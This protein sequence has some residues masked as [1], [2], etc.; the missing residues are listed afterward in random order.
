MTGDPASKPTADCPRPPWLVGDIG[1]TRARFGWVDEVDG[2]VGHVRIFA[3]ADFGGPGEAIAAYLDELGAGPGRARP[4]A[5]HAALAL[6]TPIA[7]D[8][9]AFPNSPWRFS[10]AAL[11]DSL[12]LDTLVL[13]NDFEALALALPQLDAAQL[14]W[15]GPAPRPAGTMAV[16]G[17]GTGLG[18]AGLVETESGWVALSAEGGHATLAPIDEF[19]ARLL[20]RA[21]RRVAHVSA[22][23]LL[24]GLGL[25]LLHQCVGEVLGLS[26]GTA[27]TPQIVA[28]AV[29]GSDA[30][31]ARTIEVFC[32]LLG[33]FAG[34]L[35]LTLGARGGV[36]IGGGIV[37]RLGERFFASRFRDRFEAKGRYRTYL[38]SIPTPVIL[39]T[40][41]ALVG[42]A[43]AIRRRPVPGGSGPAA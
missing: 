36:Y 4:Q 6:A 10:R 22:E 3:V 37:P 21:R 1:G 16:L 13:L 38:Q 14:R 31:A 11:R 12:R 25:P 18:T 35:A 33:G 34:N 24:S 28:A 8:A 23:R 29:D 27:T 2:R 41:A 20:E 15:Q 42:A 30:H 39:D 17:P 26:H 7:G 5:R 43:A 40:L 19:E 32:A 9:I